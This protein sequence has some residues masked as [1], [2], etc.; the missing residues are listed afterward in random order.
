MTIAYKSI[1]SIRSKHIL[2][3][4]KENILKLLKNYQKNIKSARI[5]L[6]FPKTLKIN[7]LSF[8][9]LFN[10]KINNKNYIITEN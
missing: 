3:I 1:E 2:F 9:S 5:N 8:D 10:T 4:K 7:I 6:D